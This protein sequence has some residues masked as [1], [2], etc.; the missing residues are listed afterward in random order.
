MSLIFRPSTKH[1]FV[2]LLGVEHG[3]ALAFA[4]QCDQPQ[5]FGYSPLGVVGVRAGGVSEPPPARPF[6]TIILSDNA[7]PIIN[8]PLDASFIC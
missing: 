8:K 3:L 5:P 1:A 2:R 4:L 6:S 7:Q